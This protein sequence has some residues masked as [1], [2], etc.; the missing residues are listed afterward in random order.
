M[1][2]TYEYPRPAVTADCVVI[3]KERLRVGAKAGM[4]EPKVLEREMFDEHRAEAVF[5]VAD[6]REVGF[7]L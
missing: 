7:A 5:A 6:G 2:Y 4:A 1:A 3:T